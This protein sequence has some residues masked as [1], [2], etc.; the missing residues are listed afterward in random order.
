MFKKKEEKRSIVNQLN[1][2][3]GNGTGTLYEYIFVAGINDDDKKKKEEIEENRELFAD[4]L[5][6]YIE[7]RIEEDYTEC[8]ECG[9]LV[10]KHKVAIVKRGG[11]TLEYCKHCKPPYDE[12][13]TEVDVK[14][15]VENGK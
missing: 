7:E 14:E 10:A 11:A 6:D 8:D 13:I 9:C 1:D 12:I 3:L 2:E 4:L 5:S 15:E